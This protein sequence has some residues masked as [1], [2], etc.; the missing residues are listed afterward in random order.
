MITMNYKIAAAQ[1]APVFLNKKKTIEKACSLVKEAAAN[2][3][4]L[5]VF[6]EAFVSG[7]P[8][9]QYPIARLPN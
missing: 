5:I 9:G 3:A 2:G 6:P 4:K 8:D 1:V 7:Y